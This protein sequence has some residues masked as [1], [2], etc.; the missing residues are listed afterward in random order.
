MSD[1]PTAAQWRLVAGVMGH[2]NAPILTYI[3]CDEHRALDQSRFDATTSIWIDDKAFNPLYDHNDLALLVEAMQAADYFIMCNI[4][5]NFM[6][7][8]TPYSCIV[9]ILIREREPYIKKQLAYVWRQ[10]FIE[11]TF[12]ACIEALEAK[13]KRDADGK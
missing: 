1:Q 7:T 2:P 9:D 6:S 3:G 8:S 10:T 13:G 12:W 4:Y 5:P 11:T